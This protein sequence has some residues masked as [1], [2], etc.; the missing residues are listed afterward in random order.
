MTIVNDGSSIAISEGSSLLTTV[1]S[2]FM[3]IISL[4]NRP[5]APG[6]CNIEDCE[7][8]ILR[9]MDKFCIK[10][11]SADLDKHTSLNK[12]SYLNTEPVYFESVMLL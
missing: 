10:L 7:S 5:K 11:A 4:L 1:E 6:A 3:I 9:G 2:S 8:A 12:K